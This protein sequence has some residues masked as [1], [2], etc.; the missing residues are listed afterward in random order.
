MPIDASVAPNDRYMQCA[1]IWRK[2]VCLGEK[3]SIAGE[4]KLNHLGSMTL[5]RLSSAPQV[6]VRE[7]ILKLC[8]LTYQ[9]DCLFY[10][11]NH[12]SLY[13]VRV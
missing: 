3:W 5:M 6:I 2:Q 10:L 9:H 8:P 13:Q 1:W 7:P 11:S 4:K 12:F